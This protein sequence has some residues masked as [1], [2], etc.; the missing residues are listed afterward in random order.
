MSLLFPPR[1]SFSASPSFFVLDLPQFSCFLRRLPF[2]TPSSPSLSLSRPPSTQPRASFQFSFSCSVFQPRFLRFLRRLRRLRLRFSLLSRSPA[3]KGTSIAAGAVLAAAVNAATPEG[4]VQLDV[5][6]RQ[7]HPR[8]LRRAGDNTDLTTINNNLSQGGYFATC[9][10][11]TP[12]QTLTLQLDTGSSDI[13]APA[14]DASVCQSSRSSDGCSLGSCRFFVVS[15]R[16]GKKAYS[17]VANHARQSTRPIHR[18]SPSSAR[19]RLA[20][21]TSTV[22]T[23][24]AA[25]SQTSSQLAAARSRI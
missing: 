7:P 11:G 25:I 20:Y 9:K 3:M 23:R 13:W 19:T 15:V 5:G 18:P 21:P 16:G 1:F 14:S 2:V 8:V 17:L 12:P 6:R 10:I 4:V 24:T 22:A